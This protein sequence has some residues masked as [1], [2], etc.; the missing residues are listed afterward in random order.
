MLL[1]LFLIKTKSNWKTEQCVSQKKWPKL[2]TMF[3]SRLFCFAPSTLYSYIVHSKMRKMGLYSLQ[4]KHFFIS[5]R[6]AKK[7]FF[8]SDLIKDL[9]PILSGVKSQ[10]F[11]RGSYCINIFHFIMAIV[12]DQICVSQTLRLAQKKR[13]IWVHISRDI[14]TDILKS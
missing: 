1:S 9:R 6:I 13:R 3:A 10:I 5:K 4:L 12:Y 7:F 14:E 8:F 2:D 11:T